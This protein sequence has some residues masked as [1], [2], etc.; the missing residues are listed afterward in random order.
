MVSS[1][2]ESERIVDLWVVGC[3]LWGVFEEGVGLEKR[4][5]PVGCRVESNGCRAN[6]HPCADL[7]QQNYANRFCCFKH[8]LVL[9]SHIIIPPSSPKIS[10]L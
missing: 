2:S 7:P 5:V 6:H 3:E 4:H 1:E 9:S 8:Y 10:S